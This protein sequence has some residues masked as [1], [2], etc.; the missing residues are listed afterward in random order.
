MQFGKEKRF[1]TKP[2]RLWHL[3]SGLGS[4][5]DRGLPPGVVLTGHFSA[6]CVVLY[7]T[8]Y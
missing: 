2:L 8:V 5:G 6:V 4:F 7:V 1:F 3:F